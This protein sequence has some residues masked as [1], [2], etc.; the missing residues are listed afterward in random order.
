MGEERFMAVL[1]P[2]LTGNAAGMSFP[3]IPDALASPASDA[4]P[5]NEPS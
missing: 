5:R 4:A 2:E 1:G 3:R